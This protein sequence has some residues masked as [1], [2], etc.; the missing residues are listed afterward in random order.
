[1]T[2]AGL[3]DEIHEAFGAVY[4]MGDGAL[5]VLTEQPEYFK[6]LDAGHGDDYL[7]KLDEQQ[8]VLLLE[9]I[10]SVVVECAW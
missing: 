8:L 10:Q 3:I 4:D 2:K 9:D 7:L 6:W 5:D 1:M